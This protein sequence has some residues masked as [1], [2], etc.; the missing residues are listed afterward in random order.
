MIR[1]VI[2]PDDFMSQQETLISNMVSL[3]EDPLVK[4]VVTVS[5]LP[6]TAEAFK[7]IRAKRPDILLLGGIP[8]EDPL[9]ISKVSD[10]V[11]DLDFVNRGYTIPWVAKQLGAKTMVHVSFPRHM[12]MESFGRRRAIMEAACKDLGLKFVYMSAPDPLSEAGVAGAQQFLL[13]KMPQWIAQFSGPNHEKVAFFTTNDAMAEP[14]IK[15]VAENNDAI[16]VEPG[17]ASPILGFPSA[18]GLDLKNE[19]GNW[20]AIMN[21]IEQNLNARGAKGRLGTWAYSSG[22]VFLAGMA[23]LGKRV[24]E[25]KARLSNPKDVFDALGK[26]SPN[27]SWNGSYYTDR[28]TGVRV[29]NYFLLYMDTFRLPVTSS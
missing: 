8:N 22:Y 2:A 23:E 19:Q 29:K 11:V 1:H 25:G 6:G 21:K 12:A 4:V 15:R 17:S 28:G 18:L 14:I 9:V 5:M 10:M 7:R 26:Y 3:A 16:F 13:E 20:Q 27:A 24:V